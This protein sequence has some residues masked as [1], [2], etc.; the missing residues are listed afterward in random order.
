LHPV[1]QGSHYSLPALSL[2]KFDW[3]FPVFATDKTKCKV[4]VILKDGLGKTLGSD[5]SNK[6]FSIKVGSSD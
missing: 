5:V 6:V 3:S 1:C 4:K 2:I